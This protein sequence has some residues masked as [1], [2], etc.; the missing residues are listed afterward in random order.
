MELNRIIRTRKDILKDSLKVITGIHSGLVK[1]LPSG[2][3]HLDGILGGI[4]PGD[5]ICVAGASGE[6]KTHFLNDMKRGFIK[7]AE[8]NGIKFGSLEFQWEMRDLLEVT[9]DVGQVLGKRSKEVLNEPFTEKDKAK[10]KELY[11]SHSKAKLDVCKENGTALDIYNILR[12]YLSQPEIVELDYVMVSFDHMALLK[13]RDKKKEVDELTAFLNELKF[14]FKNC[15]FVL[16][17][18]LNREYDR[19][20]DERNNLSAPMKSDLYQTDFVFFACDIVV[21]SAM[22]EKRGIQEYM[23]IFDNESNR[24]LDPF[25]VN[26]VG[27]KFSLRGEGMLYYHYLKIREFEAGI[28]NIVAKELY[29]VKTISARYDDLEF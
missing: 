19:R 27:G 16:L 3:W 28:S 21:V 9:R 17:N 6:G 5:I 10:I 25:K 18:Q 12:A 20:A 4:L 22:P 15:F 24:H 1:L 11:Q 7:N 29:P 2:I 8:K 14:E 26:K 13:G 23:K